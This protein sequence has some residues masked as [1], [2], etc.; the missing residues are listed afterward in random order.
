MMNVR[1]GG[2]VM[3]NFTFGNPGVYIE[4]VILQ[5]GLI[6]LPF[7]EALQVV[8]PHD[9]GKLMGI[10]VLFPQVGKGVYGIIGLGK[11]EFDIGKL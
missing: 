10:P 5:D 9:K 1:M 6:V 8:F 11:P 4:L 2:E 7:M 3:G